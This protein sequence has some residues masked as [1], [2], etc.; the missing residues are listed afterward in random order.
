MAMAYLKQNNDPKCIVY[1]VDEFQIPK[2]ND[3][4]AMNFITLGSI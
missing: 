3:K 1:L 2:K 4:L